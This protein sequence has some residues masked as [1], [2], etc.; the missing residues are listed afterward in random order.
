MPQQNE[1][2][3]LQQWMKL[4]QDIDALYTSFLKRWRLSPHAYLILER[5]HRG[6]TRSAE[7]TELAVLLHVTRQLVTFI[8][9]DLEERGLILRRE[10]ARDRRR[11]S[12]ALSK[13]GR[14][15]AKE[16]CDEMDALELK[17]LHALSEQERTELLERSQRYCD[18]LRSSL[19]AQKGQDG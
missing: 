4:W 6:P 17:T 18:M 14:S 9:N 16:V 7:P 5:L 8:L 2:F 3:L 10:S 15:L 12:I 19:N 13:K 1:K 11:R